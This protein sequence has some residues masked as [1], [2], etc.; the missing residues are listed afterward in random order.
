MKGA[1]CFKM[2]T[3]EEVCLLEAHEE[4]AWNVNWNP[5]GTM[6]TS[7]GGDKTIR[8][9]GKEGLLKDSKIKTS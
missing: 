1:L 6:L 8:L 5:S 7:C 9:W 4:M 3:M 2:A